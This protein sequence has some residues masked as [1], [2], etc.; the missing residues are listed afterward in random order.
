MGLGFYRIF[1]F[2]CPGLSKTFLCRVGGGF[3]FW[4]VVGG[5][6]LQEWRVGGVK[7]SLRSRG[8]GDVNARAVRLGG[9][10]HRNAAGAV[11]SGALSEV[12][13]GVLAVVEEWLAGSVGPV[14]E[15]EARG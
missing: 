7:V 3:N 13:R 15:K 2:F 9:G 1:S 6:L 5:V 14:R 4:G 10:G 12:R 8:R 11:V